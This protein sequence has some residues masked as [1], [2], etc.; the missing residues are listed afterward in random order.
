M[1]ARSCLA[2]TVAVIV[3]IATQSPAKAQTPAEFFRGKTVSLLIG[4][5]VGG[6]DD[7]WARSIAKHYGNYIPGR[8]TIVPQNASGAGG[9]MQ[10]QKRS[11]FLE[12][13]AG[14]DGIVDVQ[15]PMPAFEIATTYARLGC[16]Q[17]GSDGSLGHAQL[18][19]PPRVRACIVPRPR[20]G[21]NPCT[22][23]PY[24]PGSD[25][26]PQAQSANDRMRE[27]PTG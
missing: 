6:D 1:I 2:C 7:L 14:R 9:L 26:R 21:R 12:T 16:L 20:V 17:A 3:G 4:F 15:L 10:A 13:A 22:P 8:P 18:S 23:T 11:T 25:A 24:S 27:V 19:G 5:G